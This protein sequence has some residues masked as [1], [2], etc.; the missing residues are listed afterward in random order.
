MLKI[1]LGCIITTCKTVTVQCGLKKRYS[2][3]RYF[4]ISI[5]HAHSK[6]DWYLA[7][8]HICILRNE[9][10]WIQVPTLKGKE[11]EASKFLTS[12]P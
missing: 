7:L 11:T 12:W 5:F 2:D 4:S 6:V 1:K 9:K 3:F 8:S 10:L